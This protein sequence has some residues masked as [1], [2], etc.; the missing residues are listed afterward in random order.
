MDIPLTP[1]LEKALVEHAQEQG[2]TPEAAALCVLREGL[3]ESSSRAIPKSHEGNLRD[4]LGHHV[5]SLAS[6][7]TIPG[8]ARMSEDC[9]RKFATGLAEGR[10]GGRR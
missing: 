4:F 10:K 2:L 6:G 8:G 3:P 9:G 7:E 5:G 1:D